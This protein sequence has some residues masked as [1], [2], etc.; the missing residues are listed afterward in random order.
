[1]I[2]QRN[3]GCRIPDR[4]SAACCLEGCINC[5]GCV[6]SG[7]VAAAIS[8]GFSFSKLPLFAFSVSSS[9]SPHPQGSR[10]WCWLGPSLGAQTS[11]SR[12]LVVCVENGRK[13]SGGSVAYLCLPSGAAA[14]AKQMERENWPDTVLVSGDP[15][16]GLSQRTR[17]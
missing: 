10:P 15:F 12:S 3:K 16:G 17:L 6:A 9:A 14:A 8:R 13:A 5:S 4:N 11:A 2:L 7:V 1:M